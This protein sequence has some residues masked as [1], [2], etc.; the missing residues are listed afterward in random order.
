M[1]VCLSITQKEI[2]QKLKIPKLSMF[3]FNRAGH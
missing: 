3:P 2:E 1:S